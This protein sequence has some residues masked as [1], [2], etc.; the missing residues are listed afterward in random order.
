MQMLGGIPKSRVLIKHSQGCKEG[1]E[2]PNPL[3]REATFTSAHIFV[4]GF[5]G[6]GLPYHWA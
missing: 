4:E 2:G 1:G 5:Y 3:K 6:E